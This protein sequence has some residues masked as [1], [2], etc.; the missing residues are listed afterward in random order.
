MPLLKNILFRFVPESIIIPLRKWHYLRKLRRFSE[1]DE[2]DLGMLKNLI[3]AGDDVVDIGANIGIYTL[4]LSNLVGNKGRVYAIEP[5]PVTFQ[6]LKNNIKKLR[7]DNVIPI[8]IAV[9]DICGNVFME[10]P[11]YEK[12]GDNYYEARIVTDAGNKLK[13]FKVECITLDGLH[14]KYNFTPTFIKCDVE[15]FEWNVFKGA[16]SLLKVS[17]PILLVEINQ[18]LDNPDKKTRELISI[19]KSYDYDIYIKEGDKLQVWKGEKKTNYY[20]LKPLQVNK[21]KEKS[22]ISI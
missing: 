16:A 17:E 14:K 2:E 10:I 18:P 20:F 6:I 15:G 3:K 9:S 19:L 4:F 22:I 8:N 11:R 1:N 12:A 5:I 7:L 21:L 13:S